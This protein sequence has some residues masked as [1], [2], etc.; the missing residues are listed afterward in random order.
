MDILVQ[1]AERNL[2]LVHISIC[3]LEAGLSRKME[4]RASSPKRRLEVIKNL[5]RNGIPVNLLVSPVIPVLND[6]EIETIVDQAKAAGA[7]SASYVLLRL[8][9]EVKT[10]FVDWLE[11]EYPS[12]AR[13]VMQR[14][15]ECRGGRE[16]DAEFAQRMQGKGL[17]AEMIRDRFELACK[18][19]GYG[20][21]PILA[22]DSFLS[23]ASAQM[24][25]F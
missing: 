8:P 1:L 2:V 15:K 21:A 23:P 13:H 19:L 3:T 10:L 4:P 14:L 24:T 18:R 12:K 25:L 6:S 9:H 16:Y 5:S 17:Y 20:K 7:S 22:I 11:Q